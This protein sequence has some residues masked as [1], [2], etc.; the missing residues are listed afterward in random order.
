MSKEEPILTERHIDINTS[1]S[2]ALISSNFD[3]EQDTYIRL[4]NYSLVLGDCSNL[5]N[6]VT[7]PFNLGH[8]LPV[9]IK[10][11][12]GNYDIPTMFAEELKI[13]YNQPNKVW[14]MF[15]DLDKV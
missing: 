6:L 2:L 12:E 9:L 14:R 10:L 8:D 1:H 13:F 5:N 4:E 15:L 7:I 3:P 11:H